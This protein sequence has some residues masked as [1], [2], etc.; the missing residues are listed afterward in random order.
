L[1]VPKPTMLIQLPMVATVNAPA[2]A[3]AFIRYAH[4][5]KQ[6]KIFAT[7]GYRPVVKSV[8]KSPDMKTWKKKYN[9][10]PTFNIRNKLFGGWIKANKVWF[11]LNSGRMLGIEQAVGGPTH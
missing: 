1:I 9:T 4:A 10:G 11:D 5:P 7:S 6:Q 2:A 8:L 3:Q